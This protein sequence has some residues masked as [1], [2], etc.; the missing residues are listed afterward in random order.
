MLRIYKKTHKLILKFLS[1]DSST[2]A[3]CCKYF[4]YF[5]SAHTVPRLVTVST[6]RFS[7][8]SPGTHLRCGRWLWAT[9]WL[10]N[11]GCCGTA[12]PW[13]P[14][15]LGT[16]QVGKHGRT[17]LIRAEPSRAWAEDRRLVLKYTQR[18]QEPPPCSWPDRESITGTTKMEDG[19]GGLGG[20]FIRSGRR[21]QQDRAGDVCGS[22]LRGA[23]QGHPSSLDSPSTLCQGK[24]FAARFMNLCPWIKAKQMHERDALAMLK[25]RPQFT[26]NVQ[27]CPYLV[28]HREGFVRSH[29]LTPISR[30][31]TGSALR[32]VVR[33]VNSAR[34]ITDTNGSIKR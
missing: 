28:F 27:L 23:A 11:N 33:V 8:C 29:R 10:F 9:L 6:M 7:A 22:H 34:L 13:V 18:L 15:L 25:R 31:S 19:G 3:Q 21:Q 26:V 2:A 1:L 4:P 30:W 14:R 24:H 5:K 20:C 17:E 32:F 16:G 12:D